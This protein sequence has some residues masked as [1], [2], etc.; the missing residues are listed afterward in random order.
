MLGVSLRE[1]DA[2]G[3]R[4]KYLCL[5]SGADRNQLNFKLS[6]PSCYWSWHSSFPSFMP[7]LIY[8]YFEDLEDHLMHCR[9][10]Y[11]GFVSCASSSSQIYSRPNIQIQSRPIKYWHCGNY[12][13]LYYLQHISPL[14]SSFP[15]C[16]LLSK[17][18]SRFPTFLVNHI[19]WFINRVL[20][21]C[22]LSFML[23][24]I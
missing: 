14:T 5:G 1:Q 6:V 8:D 16:S 10:V 22:V 13:L 2:E 7:L 4:G 18:I 23:L 11:C 15:T 3:E 20:L 9:R 12:P 17:T 19:L 21:F 24:F